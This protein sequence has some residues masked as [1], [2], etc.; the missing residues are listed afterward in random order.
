VSTSRQE[1]QWVLRA[2]SN[3]RDALEL[4]LRSVQP[5]LRRY[6]TGLVGTRHADDVLQEVF[7]LVCRKLTWLQDAQLFRPWAFRIASRE[8]F[9]HLR[10][11]R[12]WPEQPGDSAMLETIPAPDARPSNELL[13]ELLNGGALSPASRA[14]LVLHFQEELPLAEVAAVLEIPL[15]T[16]KSRLAFGLTALRRELENKRSL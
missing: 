11:E 1:A 4:L 16:V 9:R 13:Q 12:Q 6:L 8:G 5:S 3:D 7:I 15:G 14:V 2:Q 10:K